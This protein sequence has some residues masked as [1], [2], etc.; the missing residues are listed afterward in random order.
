MKE[1]KEIKNT[2]DEEKISEEELNLF[3][4]KL[5]SIQKGINT[6]KSKFGSLLEN[7][8]KDDYELQYGL[9]FF[10]SKQDMMLIYITNL[11][12]YCYAKILG[13]QSITELPIIS[14]NIKISSL[15]ER[16]KVIEMKLQHLIN[17][18]INVN[19]QEKN[20]YQTT[21]EMDLKP[22]ILSLYNKREDEEEENNKEED[23]KN[24]EKPKKK[25]KKQIYLDKSEVYK[26]KSENIDFYENKEDKK[27]R[28]RQLDR[29]KEKI[30][31]SEMMRNLREEMS[32]NPIN[33]DN[34]RNS[35]YNKYM[36]EIEEYEKE[37]FVNITVPKKVIKQ[38]KKKDNNIDDLSKID[39]DLKILSNTLNEKNNYGKSK[40][41]YNLNSKKSKSF[42]N[43]K[44]K[45]K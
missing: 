15:I 13:N 8:K 38:L 44:R 2:N 39:T 14:D 32:D 25:K 22:K 26:V 18:T 31:N 45:H 6:L 29:D 28:R 34:N 40:E 1:D 27:K 19:N 12:N 4:N 7:I 10:E 24:E 41:K 21:N 20:K 30:R 17:K 42:L 43:K 9:S 33:Y 23:E 11:L 16:I 3:N 37:H 36:K 35:Y 5:H